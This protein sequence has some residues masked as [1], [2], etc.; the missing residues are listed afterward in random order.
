MPILLVKA[1]PCHDKTRVLTEKMTIPE[2][3]KKCPTFKGTMG[4]ALES[5]DRANFTF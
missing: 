4:I 2:L 3:V 5:S 1:K